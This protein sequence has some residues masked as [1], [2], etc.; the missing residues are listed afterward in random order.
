MTRCKID[1]KL[2]IVYYYNKTVHSRYR[3]SRVMLIHDAS[4]CWRANRMLVFCMT[5]R[6]GSQKGNT[7][8]DG[9]GLNL[10]SL[11]RLIFLRCHI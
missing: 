3:V 5:G 11:M 7:E 6:A 1:I 9:V 4:R 8:E 2:I 10:W